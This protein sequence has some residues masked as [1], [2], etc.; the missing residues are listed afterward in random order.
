MHPASLILVTGACF[1]V[2]LAYV[3]AVRSLTCRE[4]REKRFGVTGRS[5]SP[6]RMIGNRLQWINA[7]ELLSMVKTDPE[8]VVF[9]LLDDPSNAEP[10]RFE[11]E[12]E[13]TLPQLEEALPWMPRGTRF[14]V[15][16]VNGISPELAIRLSGITEGHSALLLEGTMSS[17]TVRFD[18]CLARQTWN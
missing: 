10:K 18:G 1:P 6:R 15:Y 4:G 8:M 14:A 12:V 7:A 2:V 5:R 17:G 3:V 9:H 11:T 13:V 16:R